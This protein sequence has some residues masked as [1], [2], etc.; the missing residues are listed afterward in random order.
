MCVYRRILNSIFRISPGY[1]SCCSRS[2]LQDFLWQREGVGGPGW[3]LGFGTDWGGFSGGPGVGIGW[4][5]GRVDTGGYGEEMGGD[6]DRDMDVGMGGDMGGG[7]WG[8]GLG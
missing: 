1:S 6:M 5:W 2:F 3:A 8:P 7:V 4:G